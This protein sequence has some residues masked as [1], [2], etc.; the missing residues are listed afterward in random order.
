MDLIFYSTKPKFLAP[1]L[2]NVV[3][4]IPRQTRENAHLSK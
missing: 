4:K 2:H 1:S 3:I